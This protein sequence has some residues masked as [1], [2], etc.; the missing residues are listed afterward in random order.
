MGEIF[1]PRF[2]VLWT[3]PSR[4]PEITRR[5][6]PTERLLELLKNRDSKGLEKSFL[7][8]LPLECEECSDSYGMRTAYRMKD[9]EGHFRELGW[10]PVPIIYC[11]KCYLEIRKKEAPIESVSRSYDR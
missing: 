10:K 8:S 11:P 4:K 6:L 2:I 3:E 7:A 9:M 1:V 5:E